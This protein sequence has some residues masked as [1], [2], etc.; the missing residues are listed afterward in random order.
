MFLADKLTPT[1]AVA[2]VAEAPEVPLDAEQLSQFAGLYWN[3]PQW[4]ARR[5]VL[6]GAK[7]HALNGAQRLHLKPVG[8]DVFE[9]TAPAGRMRVTFERNTQG[10]AQHLRAGSDGTVFERV[11]AFAPTA[12]D[13]QEFA[14]VYRSDEMDAVFRMTLKDE[15]LDSS[16]RG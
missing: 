5:I 10:R 14:G 11:E 16:G 8:D 2:V 15:A 6:E 12:T 3:Q 4:S 1:S 13:L 7:L 9:V